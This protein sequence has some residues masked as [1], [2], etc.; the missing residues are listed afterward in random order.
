MITKKFDMKKIHNQQQTSFK[1]NISFAYFLVRMRSTKRTHTHT[2]H[3]PTIP[4]HSL[5]P[6]HIHFPL[7]LTHQ[8]MR[9]TVTLGD[10]VLLINTLALPYLVDKTISLSTRSPTVGG[11]TW[12]R[13]HWGQALAPNGRKS[14]LSFQAAQIMRF[15]TTD[16]LSWCTCMPLSYSFISFLR[17]R[18]W[19]FGDSRGD[20]DTARR[21]WWWATSTCSL[22]TGWAYVCVCLSV[23]VC[24][25]VL[26]Y[27]WHIYNILYILKSRQK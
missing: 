24:V 1:F 20:S 9:S 7:W 3:T 16:T 27:T 17:T 2:T 10:K 8:Y 13:Q 12:R 6:I 14:Q 26:I 15:R 25:F 18:G 21:L 22:L 23:C 11:W 4:T 5:T 19:P